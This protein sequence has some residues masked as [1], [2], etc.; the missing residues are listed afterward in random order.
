MV[1]PQNGEKKDPNFFFGAKKK[2]YRG[3]RD[4]LSSSVRMKSPVTGQLAVSLPQD[5]LLWGG[6]SRQ[7]YCWLGFRRF[8]SAAPLG[9]PCGGALP[10][11]LGAPLARESNRSSQGCFTAH[12]EGYQLNFTFRE[13]RGRFP[14]GESRQRGNARKR[15]VPHEGFKTW[16]YAFRQPTH[17]TL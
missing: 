10:P 2:T 15:K 17:G 14:R 13:E 11:L 8:N 5:I 16:K 6:C 4:N 9:P 7:Q 3:C 12:P 1:A